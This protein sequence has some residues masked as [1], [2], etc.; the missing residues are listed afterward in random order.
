[1]DDQRRLVVTG[2]AVSSPTMLFYFRFGWSLI[3]MFRS[4]LWKDLV[5]AGS[6]G[7]TMAY[8][9]GGGGRNNKG[10]NLLELVYLDPVSPYSLDPESNPKQEEKM[11]DEVILLDAYFSMFG[12]R[13]RIALA[14]KGV[15]YEYREQNLLNKGQYLLDMNPIHKKIPVLIH[16]GKPICESLIIVEYIDEVWKNNPLLPSDPYQRAQARFWADF[17]DKKVNDAGKR[18]WYLKGE[19]QQAAKEEFIDA[20]QLLETELGDKPYFGGD[21]FGFVDL[22]LI[23]FYCWFHAYETFGNFSTEE[24]CPKLIEWAE[25]C[26]KIESVSKSL[27]C[28]I[29]V[30]EFVLILKKKYGVK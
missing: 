19:Q 20:L 17:I 13:V 15:E 30:Y 4:E 7:P 10:S 25:R 12:M 14:E 21:K 26:E 8:G 9:R 16:N 3:H 6:G 29:K 2:Q 24:H 28:P 11:L 27:A 22:A 5:E 18:I 1:M 23:P